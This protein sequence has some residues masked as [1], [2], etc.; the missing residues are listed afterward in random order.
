MQEILP[1]IW[2]WTTEHPDLG[3]R[4]SSYAVPGAGLALDPLLPDGG[5]QRLGELGVASVALTCRHHRRDAPELQRALGARVFVPEPG[6]HEFEGDDE[7]DV[8][9]YADGDRVAG[10]VRAHALGAIAPDDFVLHITVDSGALAFADG[11]VTVDGSIGFVPDSLMDDPPAVKTATAERVR[12]LLELDFD[13]L[14][15][16]HGDPV[17]SGGKAALRAWLDQASR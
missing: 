7:L 12:E 6:L 10:G 9:G 8:Q 3:Q 13:A 14:L 4:V 15:F 17:P 5:A 16:A 1:G 11:L 2:H